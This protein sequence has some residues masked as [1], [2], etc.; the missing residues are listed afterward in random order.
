MV[1]NIRKKKTSNIGSSARAGSSKNT[2]L[3]NNDL[4][5][6]P[7][8]RKAAPLSTGVR[9]EA[10][11]LSVG[12]RSTPNMSTP[13]APLSVGV[14]NAPNMSKAPAPTSVGVRN[15]HVTRSPSSDTTQQSR[16]PAP[17]SVGVR[18][19]SGTPVTRSPLS[20][21]SLQSREARAQETANSRGLTGNDRQIFIENQM[22]IGTPSAP[23]A[24]A[25]P[26]PTADFVPQRAEVPPLQRLTP[27]REP[28]APQPSLSF[29]QQPQ[30]QQPQIQQ[31]SALDDARN[32]YMESLAPDADIMR[33]KQELADY[34]ADAM[35]AVAGEEG[36]GRGRT[37]NLV[38]GRQALIQEQTA[39]Q[40]ANKI[41]RL[42][43]SMEEKAMM[44]QSALVQL[45]FAQTDAQ[46]I[47]SQQKPFEFGGN[48]VQ[49]DPATGELKTIA[50]APTQAAEGFTLGE[51]QARYDAQ[52]NLIATGISAPTDPYEQMKQS[53]EIQKLQQDLAGGGDASKLLSI[54][55]LNDLG[56]NTNLYGITSGQAIEGIQS[57]EIVTEQQKQV[58]AKVDSFADKITLIDRILAEGSGLKGAVGG[59]GGLGRIQLSP[60]KQNEFTGMIDQLLGEET[61]ATLIALKDQGGTLGAL[62]DAELQILQSTAATFANA[63]TEPGSGKYNISEASFIAEL[64]RIKTETKRLAE[65]SMADIM[66]PQQDY[67]NTVGQQDAGNMQN[68]YNSGEMTQDEYNE[69]LNFSRVDSDTKIA[70]SAVSK[71]YPDGSSGGQC[72]RF[73]NNL[74][75]LGVA[76]TYESKMAKTDPSIGQPNNPPMAGDM[77]VMPYSWTG[78]T[79][80][81]ESVTPRSD[82]TF[83]V[84]VVDSNWGLDEKVQRH[85][86]NSR[87]IAGYARQSLKV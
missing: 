61:M 85:T 22:G 13:S 33:Q 66:Q 86:L 7:K 81:V 55:D 41:A 26:T 38:R 58:I 72:G 64:N 4:I 67:S 51:G 20:D 63:E 40:E 37:V 60:T 53:L 23:T 79:G 82:G 54:K 25:Q 57:G 12:V 50:E 70:M 14:R 3:K 78:H 73:V 46:S 75:G 68:M 9:K 10:S 32:R 47:I 52:G 30:T 69:F 43:I 39:I 27:E 28:T 56:L 24:P 76:D 19:S 74:T 31:P 44:Q 29:A 8:A 83:D 42:N 87:K 17:L 62:S 21:T 11:P 35:S 71:K 36:L 18:G 84:N 15:T 2:F 5:S 48:L 59:Y 49:Y 16:V 65:D 1:F 34:Q 45:G 80:I 6:K 77:F